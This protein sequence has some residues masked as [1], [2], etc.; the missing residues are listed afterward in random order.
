MK[1]RT[2]P[3]RLTKALLE[4]TSDMRRIGIIDEATLERITLRLAGRIATALPPR[5]PRRIGTPPGEGPRHEADE[6]PPPGRHSKLGHRP[7]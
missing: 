7:R 5:S 1:T 2:Y 4:T 3:G 6:L